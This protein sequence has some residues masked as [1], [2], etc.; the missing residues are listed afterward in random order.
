MSPK[1]AKALIKLLE[2]P[3]ACLRCPHQIR[4]HE[5]HTNRSRCE[6]ICR[7]CLQVV[8]LE[9]T[10]RVDTCPC[11]EIG[12]HEAIKR[13]WIT[14]EEEGHLDATSIDLMMG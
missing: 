14:L 8:G 5:Y 10:D 12:P 1:H 4:I 13:T 6:S 11:P 2:K 9:Q 7:E 3:D